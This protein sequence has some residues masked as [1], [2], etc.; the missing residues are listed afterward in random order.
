MGL[1][2]NAVGRDETVE[3]L[4]ARAVGGTALEPL[5]EKSVPSIRLWEQDTV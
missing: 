4:M 1:C 5:K 2:V 3:E